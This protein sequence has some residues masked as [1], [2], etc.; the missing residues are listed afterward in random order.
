MGRVESKINTSST[1]NNISFGDKKLDK[2]LRGIIIGLKF[3]AK[4]EVV[5]TD[6]S[7]L[8]LSKVIL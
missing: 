4:R 2:K 6:N 1:I 3:L 5:A 8:S 7:G